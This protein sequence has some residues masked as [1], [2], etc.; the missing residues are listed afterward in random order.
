MLENLI[1]NEIDDDNS[2]LNLQHLRPPIQDMDLSAKLFKQTT[3]ANLVPFVTPTKDDSKESTSR[4]TKDH[5]S[6]F[7]RTDFNE[8]D[9][10]QIALLPC[11]MNTLFK[12]P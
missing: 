10:T 4:Y 3:P 11:I 2:L 7:N 8:N 6:N 12:T 5:D 9:D 1:K